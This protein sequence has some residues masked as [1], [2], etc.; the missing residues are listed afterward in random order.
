MRAPYIEQSTIIGI[1]ILLVAL[2]IWM[3]YGINEARLNYGVEKNY[4]KPEYVIEAFTITTSN[5]NAISHI[6]KGDELRHLSN[7]T[8]DI[9]EPCVI[10]FDQLESVRVFSAQTAK[11]VKGGDRILLGGNVTT[12]EHKHD[13]YSW[14]RDYC[15]DSMHQTRPKIATGDTELKLNPHFKAASPMTSQVRPDG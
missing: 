11:I 15:L 7:G 10:L 14:S 5:G 2:G 1:G 13:T 4:G 6:V 9:V 8:T 12:S 3:Q